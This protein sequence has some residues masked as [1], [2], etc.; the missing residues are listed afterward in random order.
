MEGPAKGLLYLGNYL[1]GISNQSLGIRESNIRRGGSV[2]LIV[3]NDL[4]SVISEVT[5]TRVG[6]SQID[7][8]H[9]PADPQG[10]GEQPREPRK[11]RNRGER[12]MLYDRGSRGGCFLSH[13][14]VF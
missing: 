7:S 9:V 11:K 8:L 1:G 13:V 4:D 5:D 6:G 14:K 12:G 2:S 10:G 3:G